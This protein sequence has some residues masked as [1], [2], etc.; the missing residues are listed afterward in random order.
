MKR[1]LFGSLNTSYK[2]KEYLKKEALHKNQFN[3]SNKKSA[4]LSQITE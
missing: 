2:D 3:N 1:K 4:L